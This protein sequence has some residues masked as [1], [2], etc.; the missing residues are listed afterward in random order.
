VSAGKEVA[1]MTPEEKFVAAMKEYAQSQTY[2]G[3]NVIV[4]DYAAVLYV[5]E[6]EPSGEIT[7][8]YLHLTAKRSSWHSL[9]GLVQTLADYV[10]R[11]KR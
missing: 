10:Y 8:S 2:A 9:R 1:I 5:E 7:S 11:Q 4:T 6:F 3:R